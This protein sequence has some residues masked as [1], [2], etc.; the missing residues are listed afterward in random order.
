M[1]TDLIV[2]V[3]RGKQYPRSPGGAHR[4]HSRCRK[5]KSS[6]STSRKTRPRLP[7]TFPRRA[8]RSSVLP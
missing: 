5:R 8:A 6:R 3:I 4:H 7:A 2:G 1:T